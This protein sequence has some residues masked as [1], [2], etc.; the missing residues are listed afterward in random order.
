MRF[1]EI[2]W[3]FFFCSFFLPEFVEDLRFYL[4][5]FLFVSAYF[6]LFVVSYCLMGLF[7]VQVVL[8]V[9][10]CFTFIGTQLKDIGQRAASDK[11]FDTEKALKEVI[12]NHSEAIE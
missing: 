1:S 2:Y 5:V 3:W 6:V 9:S 8:T 4:P 7:V 12:D 11:N 10:G